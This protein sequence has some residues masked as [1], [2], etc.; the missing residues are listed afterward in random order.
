MGSIEH[1]STALT[2]QSDMINS[3]VLIC[4]FT[5]ANHKICATRFQSNEVKIVEVFEHLKFILY[6]QCISGKQ[7][8]YKSSDARVLQLK[9]TS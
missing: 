5:I 6:W 1:E 8:T 3:S 7:F 4:E 9:H 2:C